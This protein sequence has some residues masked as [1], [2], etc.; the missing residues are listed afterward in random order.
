MQQLT[1][2]EI[3]KVFALHLGCDAKTNE[4]IANLYAINTDGFREY[5]TPDG[6]KHCDPHHKTDKLLL[7][8]L[9]QISDE[10]AIEVAKICTGLKDSTKFKVCVPNSTF[11]RY[12]ELSGTS[13]EVRIMFKQCNIIMC[14][15]YNNSVSQSGNPEVNL[16]I[17]YLI[18]KGY[19]VPL[20]FGIDH[21][22]NGK[23]AIELGIA[24][25]KA[26]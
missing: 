18:S 3:A 7:T 11:W 2:K 13:L 17:Q 26:S 6:Y 10:D 15:V 23:T 16:A 8:P 21:W 9:S 19:D 20:W 25:N 12:V 1:N 24:I 4:P 5:I 14:N 22:A